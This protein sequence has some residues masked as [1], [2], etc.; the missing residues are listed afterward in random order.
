ML[1]LLLSNSNSVQMSLSRQARL[2]D[3]ALHEPVR[4]LT[5]FPQQ[6]Y[7]QL[8]NI[9][10]RIWCLIITL[11]PAIR[12]VLAEAADSADLAVRAVEEELFDV[13]SFR[14]EMAVM[15]REMTALLLE[16]SLSLQ[17]GRM[18][19][20][21]QLSLVVSMVS[22]IQCRFAAS[23]NAVADRVRQGKTAMMS[24]RAIVPVTVFLYSAVQLA[25][26]VLLLRAG[27]RRL[28]ELERPHGYDD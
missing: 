5:V 7:K 16:C 25:E 11:E 12:Q 3:E 23:M 10:R 2:L 19:E 4:F 18:G 22:S 28:L 6:Q 14:G 13:Q 24:S 26:Q 9:Q 21:H 1:R 27:V 15:M 8:R 17:T 20:E